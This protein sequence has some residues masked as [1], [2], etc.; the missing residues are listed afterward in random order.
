MPVFAHRAVDAA[1]DVTDAL[2]TLATLEIP[3]V[4]TSG[5]APGAEQGIP[6]LR[7]LV[8][9]FGDRVRILAG[10]SVRPSNVR[11]IVDQT[12]VREVHFGYPQ[13]AE[14]DRVRAVVAALHG[15]I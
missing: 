6:V 13:G 8:T 3:R 14:P 4:L 2:Q 9:D 10:G 5:G 11:R 1:R 7:R 12:G 15:E